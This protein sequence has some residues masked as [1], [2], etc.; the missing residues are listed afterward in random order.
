MDHTIITQTGIPLR[1]KGDAINN[2]SRINGAKKYCFTQTSVK[3]P[4]ITEEYVKKGKEE[5]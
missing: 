4:V 1:V 3:A 5:N 2:Y